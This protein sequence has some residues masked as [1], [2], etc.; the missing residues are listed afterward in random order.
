MAYQAKLED[1]MTAKRDTTLLEEICVIMDHV[2][3][4]HNV[5]MQA[6]GRAMGLTVLQERAGWL[7]LTNLTTKEKAEFLDGPIIPQGLF[8][9]AVT[10]MQK[11]FEENKG[12]D[13]VL[14]LCLPRRVQTVAPAVQR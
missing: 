4:L 7:G 8:G 3:R 12:D 1:D 14:Q 13:E 9:T 5:A 2:L 10:S 6:T 11:R